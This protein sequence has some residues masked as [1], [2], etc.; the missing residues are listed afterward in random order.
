MNSLAIT[1]VLCSALCHVFRDFFTKQSNDKQLFVWWMS[2]ISNLVVLPFALWFAMTGPTISWLGVFFSLG[3]GMVHASYW[4]LYSKAYEGADISH[5][6]PIIRSAPALVLLLAV[7]FLKESVSIIGLLGILM[8]TFGLYT[9]NLKGYSLKHLF[10]PFR[11]ASYDKH[12]KIAFLAMIAVATYSTLDKVAVSMVHP[13]VYM[14]VMVSSGMVFY[15]IGMRRMKHR[16]DWNYPLKHNLKRLLWATLF[17]TLNYPLILF[18]IQFTNVSY[19]AA[20]RQISVVFMVLAG[21]FLLKESYPLIR[22]VSSIIIFAGALM[23]AFA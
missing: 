4:T 11:A 22:F 10:E 18:A 19:V 9:I 5:V 21:A 8:V 15:T 23:I 20:F 16:P 2:F 7:V 17:G 14:Y 1:L 12:V 3:M 6:Y 13:I